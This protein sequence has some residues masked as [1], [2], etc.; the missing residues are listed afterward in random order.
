[1]LE[2]QLRVGD[3]LISANIG[4][5]TTGADDESNRLSGDNVEDTK[6]T[7]LRRTQVTSG[8]FKRTKTVEETFETGEFRFLPYVENRINRT[9]TG[10]KDVLSG[11]FSGCWMSLYQEGGAAYVAH[12][13]C[14]ANEKKDCKK[15]WRAHKA[16][17]TVTLDSEFKPDDH[18]KGGTKVFGLFTSQGGRYTITCELYNPEIANP[19][20]KKQWK[21]ELATRGEVRKEDIPQLAKILAKKKRLQLNQVYRGLTFEIQDISQPIA[22]ENFPEDE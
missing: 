9:A 19:Y 8:F 18:A 14:D 5:G 10:G 15:Q 12:V 3:V 2:N 1:M 11:Y 20:D 17:N 7:V 4:P 16:L 22:A 21:A 6:L 13:F